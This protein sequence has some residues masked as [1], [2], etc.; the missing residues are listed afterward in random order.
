MAIVSQKM[1]QQSRETLIQRVSL[2]D[3]LD[4]L[5]RGHSPL[6]LVERLS[7]RFAEVEQNIQA[8]IP[9]ENRFERLRRDAESLRERYPQPAARPPLFG[10]L[11]G[12][13]DIFHADGFTT[14]A[15]ADLPHPLFAGDEAHIRDATEARRRLGS[16]QNSYHRICLLRAGSHAQSTQHRPYARWQQQWIGGCG[17]G[18]FGACGAS[19]HRQSARSY[20]PRL[21]AALSA[22]SRRLAASAQPD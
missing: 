13:K 3:D 7:A 14:R 5:R 10:A 20:V 15:G 12:V 17:G 19:V 16:W 2:V 6:A 4:A 11:L 1:S 18:R 8:F 21:I 22:I 9:E